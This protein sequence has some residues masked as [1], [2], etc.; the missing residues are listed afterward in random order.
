MAPGVMQ[1]HRDKTTIYK[2]Y[3]GEDII[4]TLYSTILDLILKISPE[5]VPWHG[6]VPE[7]HQ[8]NKNQMVLT[9]TLEDEN[10][11]TVFGAGMASTASSINQRY[12]GG[13]NKLI[14][15]VYSTAAHK[16]EDGQAYIS[17]N[18]DKHLTALLQVSVCN[19]QQSAKYCKVADNIHISS[20]L[21]RNMSI[22]PIHMNK[23]KITPLTN[24]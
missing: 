6:V 2:H 3:L 7:N 16:D 23:M 9:T 8:A 11:G 14:K 24:H 5:F 19:I 22:K 21:V 17:W 13:I 1:L 12:Q 4:W 15:L 10:I 20:P 18:V